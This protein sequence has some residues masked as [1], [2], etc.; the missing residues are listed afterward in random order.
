MAPRLS[1][2]EK[3]VILGGLIAAITLVL[4]LVLLYKIGPQWMK[5]PNAGLSDPN[6]DKATQIIGY[7]VQH[8]ILYL[9]LQSGTILACLDPA[10]SSG[11]SD[12]CQ[13]VSNE[14]ARQMLRESHQCNTGTI[15]TKIPP[16]TP[17]SQIES[18]P[19][20]PSIGRHQVNHIVLADGTVWRLS[21]NIAEDE[22]YWMATFIVMMGIFGF[23][24]GMI[25]TALI[26]ALS[27]RLRRSNK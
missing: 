26:L 25:G 16:G 22:G 1:R 7:D 2:D 10:E 24:A 11:R 18:Y 4:I 8:E 23:A 6:E 12:D 17:V 21:Q 19:C 13:T 14:V 27:R 15:S 5:L 20:P 9:R 3:S